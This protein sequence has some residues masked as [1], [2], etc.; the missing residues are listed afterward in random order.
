MFAVC[1]PS[2]HQLHTQLS[3]RPSPSTEQAS[4]AYNR[5]WDRGKESWG[6]NSAWQGGDNRSHVRHREDDYGADPKRR[7]FNNGVSICL[8]VAWPVLT[9]GTTQGYQ[10]HEGAQ[11]YDDSSSGAY[12]HNRQQD[13]G[14]H[15]HQQQQQHYQRD[16]DYGH[17]DRGRGGNGGG[18]PKKR[19]QPSEPSPHVIF[20]GLDPDFT[21]ADVCRLFHVLPS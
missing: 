3:L 4:M 19:L 8:P 2:L 17:D 5:D 16:Q 13:Y 10:G 21:E 20:L 15:H 14:H 18:F 12:G 1:L 7:K 9:T 6:D 11:G